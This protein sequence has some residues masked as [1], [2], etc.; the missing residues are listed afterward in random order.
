MKTVKEILKHTS[1]NL[2]AA[3]CLQLMNLSEI[4]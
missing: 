3:A 4:G 1:K 2:K